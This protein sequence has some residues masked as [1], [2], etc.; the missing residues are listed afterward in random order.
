MQ[1]N[2]VGPTIWTGDNLDILRGL[3]SDSVDLVY[4]DPPFNSN[5]DYSTPVG[6]AAAAATFKDTWTL[7]DLD[8]AWMGLIADEHP[9]MY[10]TLEAAGMTHGK[11][12]Q[13]YLCIVSVRL[14]EMRRVLKDTGNIY[15]HCDP[16]ASHYLKLVMDSVFGAAQFRNE[17]IWKRTS[18]HNSSRR[19]GPNH[20]A[21]LFYNNSVKFT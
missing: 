3:N 13:S 8:V 14:L 6:R 1:P 20:D 18:A 21:I 2:F 16:T 9:A 19:Y 11:G 15:L 4:L 5:R 12:M 10:K 17:I 7:S